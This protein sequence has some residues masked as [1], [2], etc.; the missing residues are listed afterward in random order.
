LKAQQRYLS[1]AR[2]STCLRLCGLRTS[3]QCRLPRMRSI[4]T[5]LRKGRARKGKKQDGG[6][7]LGID[8]LWALPRTPPRLQNSH[9]STIQDQPRPQPPPILPP[10]ESLPAGLPPI[11]DTGPAS[12]T[13]SAC[14]A[15]DASSLGGSASIDDTGPALPWAAACTAYDAS[16]LGGPPPINNTSSASPTTTA[17]G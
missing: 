9:P 5:A 3:R 6:H 12:P 2:S 8:R 4:C 10:D 15:R 7:P 13:T 14:T 11:V 1:Y 16:L 17:C